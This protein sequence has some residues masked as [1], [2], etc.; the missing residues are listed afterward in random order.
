MYSWQSKLH[1]CLAALYFAI[2]H[3][4]HPKMVQAHNHFGLWVNKGLNDCA[5]YAR[6]LRYRAVHRAQYSVASACLQPVKALVTTRFCRLKIRHLDLDAGMPPLK[7][8]QSNVHPPSYQPLCSHKHSMPAQ[9]ERM[10]PSFMG[11][12]QQSNHILTAS[13]ISLWTY[14]S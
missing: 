10:M 1:C 8:H 4:A 2:M 5:S 14:S 9:I 3:E 7:L 13:L 6:C 12:P 11:S